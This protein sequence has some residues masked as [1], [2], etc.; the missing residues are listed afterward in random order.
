MTALPNNLYPAVILMG[1]SGCGKSTF[2][3]FLRKELGYAFADGDKFH[4]A[5]NIE[6]MTNGMPLN[7]V[8]RWPWLDA[9]CDHIIRTLN[10]GTPVA[11]ACSALRQ[12]YRERLRQSTD[13][14]V[15][16]HLVARREEIARRFAHRDQ[17][18]MP[19]NLIDSQFETLESTVGEN[20]I[21][22]VDVSQHMLN[23]EKEILNAVKR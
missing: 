18:F 15:F 10:S 4:P 22:E 3:K 20:D 7:D 2:G 19:A 1:V 11:I 14:L 13:E 16:I 8:D 21:L 17:H 5:A 12:V 9:I 23:V 6:K